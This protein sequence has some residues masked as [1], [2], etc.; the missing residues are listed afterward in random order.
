MEIKNWMEI[1]GKFM[2]DERFELPLPGPIYQNVQRIMGEKNLDIRE[3]EKLINYDQSLTVRVLRMANSAFYRGWQKVATVREAIMRLG[4]NEVMNILLLIAQR[5]NFSAQDPWISKV[6]H[7]LWQHSVASA[8]GAQ[9][10]ARNCRFRFLQQEAF[11]GGL[12]HDVGKSFLMTVIEK[13]KLKGGLGLPLE[14]EIIGQVLKVL[15]TEN[16][17]SLLN[18]WHLPEEYCSVARNHHREEIDPNDELLVMVRLANLAC[19]KME[20]GLMVDPSLIL[21]TR[22]EVTWL[23]FS[24]EAIT[25]LQAKVEEAV[26]LTNL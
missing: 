3:V 4:T 12:L 20:I 26:L 13:I 9:W 10:I 1:L 15:H 2:R 24:E 25:A 16:G 14:E 22:P 17:Y 8:V 6:M 7:K 5:E 18:K 11:V 21:E 19:H 23:A